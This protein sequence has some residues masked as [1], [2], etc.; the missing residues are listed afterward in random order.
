MYIRNFKVNDAEK[1]AEIIERNLK[2][3][4]E[5]EYSSEE[6]DFCIRTHNAAAIKER[7]KFSHMYV[8]CT[9][10]DEVIGCG[11]IAAYLGSMEES[12]L[13]L[14]YVHP[15][16]H[17]KG[18]GREIVKNLERDSYY[19]RAKRIEVPAT[20][21]SYEFYK[22]LGY[23]FKNGIKNFDEERCYRMEKFNDNH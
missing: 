22:K 20:T 15:K 11:T 17:N 7:A 1:V 3:I 2:D 8:A 12:I 21:N 16:Y 4:N 19:L 13:D 5:K 6:L 14:V 10:Q 9:N 18:I 23:E